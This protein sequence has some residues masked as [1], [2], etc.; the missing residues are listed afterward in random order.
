MTFVSKSVMERHTQKA[1]NELVGNLLRFSQLDLDTA[2]RLIKSKL[3]HGELV[4]L[5]LFEM[6]SHKSVE[7]VKKTL[8]RTNLIKGKTY[9]PLK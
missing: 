4:S 1:Q 7:E 3:A 2:S 6:K 9:L 8:G 5:N